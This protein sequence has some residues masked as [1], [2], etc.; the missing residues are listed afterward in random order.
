MQLYLMTME[1]TGIE[2]STATIG[3]MYLFVGAVGFFSAGEVGE[4]D[5]MQSERRHRWRQHRNGR[6]VSNGGT[7]W[8]DYPRMLMLDCTDDGEK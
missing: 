5:V 2:E 6:Q 7:S 8:L 4:F 1:K 3:N